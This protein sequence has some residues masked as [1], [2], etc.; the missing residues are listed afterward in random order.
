MSVGKI[1]NPRTVGDFL[2][3]LET[4]SI[5]RKPGKCRQIDIVYGAHVYRDGWAAIFF[6]SASIGLHATIGAEEMCNFFGVETIF[7]EGFFPG[8]EHE[9]VCV[10]KREQHAFGLTVRAITLEHRWR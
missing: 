6:I 1:K 10:Y 8:Q 9:V 5:H 7:R 3:Y 4:L 2:F